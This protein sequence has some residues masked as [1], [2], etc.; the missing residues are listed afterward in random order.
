MVGDIGLHWW[1]GCNGVRCGGVRSDLVGWD[2][3]ARCAVELGGVGE[4][5]RWKG[6]WAGQWVGA[7]WAVGE[8]GSEKGA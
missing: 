8:G 6:G 5:D 3:V 1:V 7:V 2:W 4:W